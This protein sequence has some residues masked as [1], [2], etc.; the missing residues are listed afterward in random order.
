MNQ[1]LALALPLQKLSTNLYIADIF[2]VLIITI[3][4]YGGLLLFKKTRS[5]SVLVGIGIILLLY[6]LSQVF[7][8]YLTTLFLQAF[9]GVFLIMLVVMF[10]E[11]LRRFFEFIAVFGTRQMKREELTTADALVNEI[12]QAVSNMAHRKI[13]ALIVLQGA[14]NI[15]RHIEGGHVLD[16][17]ISQELLESIFDPTSPGHDGAVIVSR[18]RASMLGAHLPLSRNFQ[19]IG[20]HGTRHS[21]ALGIAERS[22]SLAVVVSEESGNISTARNGMLQSVSQKEDL[23]TTLH[24]FFQE[25]FPTAAISFWGNVLRKN[26]KEKMLALAIASCLWFFFV[27]EAGTVR[28]NYTV[29]VSFHNL[30]PEFVVEDA[31]PNTVTITLESRGKAGEILDLNDLEVAIDGESLKPGLQR[32][33]ITQDLIE[34]PVAFTVVNVS[35]P[36]VQLNV[37]TYR[38]TTLP[39]TARTAGKVAEGYKIESITLNPGAIPVLVAEQSKT[40]DAVLTEAIDVSDL[41]ETVSIPATI[42]LP[43]NIRLEDPTDISVSVTIEITRK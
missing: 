2:D 13:G 21:A 11:E 19:Q 8:L 35:P 24:K 37:G 42:V 25:K 1:L 17:V 40:P 32:I 34:K 7:N 33:A 6:G 43:R 31:K 41:S 4:I 15:E 12:M 16:G 27:Y 20:K 14:E 3:I 38:K 22:D 23:E 5:F 29:P 28:R 39:I 18:D 36:E 30:P 10:Q 26:T 9:F